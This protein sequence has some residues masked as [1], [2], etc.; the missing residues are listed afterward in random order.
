MITKYNYVGV[1]SQSRHEE[2]ANPVKLRK[3]LMDE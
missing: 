2:K 3:K 1:P